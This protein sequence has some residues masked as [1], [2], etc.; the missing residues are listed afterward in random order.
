MA[1]LGSLAVSWHVQR[2]YNADGKDGLT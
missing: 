1:S 2:D